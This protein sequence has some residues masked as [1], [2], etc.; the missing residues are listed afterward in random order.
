MG[1]IRIYDD[2]PSGDVKIA[3][4]RSTKDPPFFIGKSWY[5]HYVDWAMFN[6]YVSLPAD[7]SGNLLKQIMSS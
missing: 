2:I 7:A 6:S 4:E 5:I 1:F 3:M